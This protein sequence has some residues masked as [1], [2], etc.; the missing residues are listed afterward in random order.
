M[1][2]PFRPLI[3]VFAFAF[4]LA[5]HAAEMAVPFR[6]V[7]FDDALQAA[8]KEN[9]LVFVDFFTTWCEPCKRLDADTFT[10]AGVG[11]LVGGAAVALKLDAEKEG[12]AV[13]KRYKVSAYPTLLLVKADGTEVDRIVGYRPPAPFTTEFRNLLVMAQT[14]K[15]GLEQARSIVAQQAKPEVASG[16]AEDAQ[17]HF[18]LAK[19]LIVAGNYEEALKELIWCW[20]EGKKDPDFSTRRSAL[21]AGEMARV[22]KDL[23]AA[24]DAM[25]VRRD[26]A[27]QRAIANKGGAAVIQD[28]IQM[29]KA[30]KQEEDTLTV[31]DQIPEGDR[32]RATI[33]IYLFDQLVERQRYNDAVWPTLF[34]GAVS[35]LEQSKLRAKTGGPAMTTTY[36]IARTAKQVEALAGAG[37][38]EQARELGERLI[39]FESTDETKQLLT[40]HATRA[41][42]PELFASVPVVAIPK[43]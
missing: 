21:V 39:A 20:D 37:Q 19:K 41:G 7:T 6:R 3:A 9:K 14:G 36:I 35:M 12:L 2:P 33:S 40:K 22:A 17:P 15:T 25:I 30:L 28:V 13:A 43:N 42:Q 32:R 34:S 16:D 8:A 1:H 4:A 24:R 29:N 5:A 11:R 31:F 10:D 26:Q 27:K 18:D 38:L 23:P